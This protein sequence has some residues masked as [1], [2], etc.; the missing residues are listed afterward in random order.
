LPIDEHGVRPQLDLQVL[1]ER[2]GVD[3][4]GEVHHGHIIV[5]TVHEVRDM[6]GG[7]GDFCWMPPLRTS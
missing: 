5:Y 1:H 7:V 6:L 3:G 2:V 4:A